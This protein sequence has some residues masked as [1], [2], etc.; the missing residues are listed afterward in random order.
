MKIGIVT[1]HHV[2]NDGAVLQAYAQQQALQ[3]LFPDAT[4][5]IIDFRYKMIEK[6]ERFDI[7]KDV[8]KFRKSAFF[9]LRKYIT[10]RNFVNRKLPLSKRRIVADDLQEAT[11]FINQHYDAVVVGSDEVWKIDY[12]KF[13]RPFPNI[14]WLPQP[15]NV[16]RI[17]SAAT[18]NTLN[19]SALKEG[20]RSKAVELLRDFRLIGVR[21][22]FTYD[23]VKTNVPDAPLSLMPDPTFAL[24]MEESIYA[25]AK[26]KLE[27][28]GVDL[29][30]PILGLSLSSNIKELKELSAKV[31]STFDAMG[32]Q[33]VSIGQYN[34]YCHVNLTAQL[35]P[36]EWA[37]VYRFFQFCITDRFHSTI[38]SIRNHVNFVS[39]DFS[40]R[41][42]EDVTG[43]IYDLLGRIAMLNHHLNLKNFSID[44]AMTR[45]QAVLAEGSI[46]QVSKTLQ[47]VDQQLADDYDAF[48]QKVKSELKGL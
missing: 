48:L 41:Y 33:V 15:I 30:K 31:F 37:H 4:V 3:R 47:R 16:I 6:R 24:T 12:K 29:K 27:A 20:D 39:V 26:Q 5:E 23:F 11:A 38:F 46:G 8:L 13:S 2:I 45:I 22:R 42:K 10:V 35:D 9:K 17:A 34:E 28:A 1:Y 25:T 14:Y 40:N 18:A 19:L 7:L 44:E 36:L 43:K 21:D 32:Y